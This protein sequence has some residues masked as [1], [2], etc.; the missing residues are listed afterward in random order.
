MARTENITIV[1]DDKLPS[2]ISYAGAGFSVG[3]GLTPAEWGVVIGIVTALLTFA[4]NAIYQ[5]RRERR[6]QQRH[7]LLMQHIKQHGP[8]GSMREGSD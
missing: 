4:L 5:R 6:E 7:E 2:T 8:L 1:A 3:S